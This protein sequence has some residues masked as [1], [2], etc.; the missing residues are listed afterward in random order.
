MNTARSIIRGSF[1]LPAAGA[2]AIGFF[3]LSCGGE[4]AGPFTGPGSGPDGGGIVE[5]AGPGV[6]VV[7]TDY[8]TGSFAVLDPA[9][10]AVMKD[11]GSIH[12]D[13]VARWSPLLRQVVVVNRL[14]QDNLQFL[15]PRNRFATAAQHGVGNGTNPRDVLILSPGKAFVTRHQSPSLLVMNPA[16]GAPIREIDL[17]AFAD[18]D[19]VPEMDQMLLW[20]NRV[21]VTLQRLDQ[22]DRFRANHDSLIIA[23]D[24]ETGE[25]ADLDPAVPGAQGWVLPFRSPISPMKLS[26]DGKS[27]ALSFPGNFGAL[28]GGLAQMDASGKAV[29][30]I[31]EQTLGGD[32]NAWDLLGDD[33]YVVVST[34]DYKTSLAHF[35][36]RER[37]LVREL[38]RTGSFD[39][40]GLLI[41]PDRGELLVCDRTPARPGIR[42]FSIPGDEERG[43]ARSTGLPPF[44]LLAIP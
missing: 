12:S 13:A 7:T 44:E 42:V 3:L 40:A 11:L 35:S 6:F 38:I 8:A 41:L 39:L 25:V 24:P 10:G 5:G 15:D 36:L 31:D 9:G 22:K 28:D 1:F 33:L 20:N 23:L 32:I 27:F 21:Y 19:G 43:A 18:P 16:T 29:V 26:P 34:P 4:Q 2:C 37:R 14:R 17:S 30:L